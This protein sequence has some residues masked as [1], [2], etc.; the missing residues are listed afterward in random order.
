MKPVEIVIAE[1]QH[2]ALFS[3]LYPGDKDEHGAVLLCGL[4][5]THK[6]RR[7]LVREV[8]LAQDGVGYVS[9]TRGYRQLQPM[10]IAEALD[11][12][13]ENGLYYLAVHNHGAGK[14]VAF[15]KVDTDSHR[16]SYPSLIEI[17]EGR[18]VGALVFA[19]EACAGRIWSREG[20]ED[21]ASYRIIGLHQKLL[22]PKPEPRCD[23]AFDLSLYDRQTRMLGSTGQKTICQLKIGVIGAGG[24]GSIL[25]D[26]L[27]HKGICS[28]VS[29]DPDQLDYTNL[30]R[31][32]GY[33]P[34]DRLRCILS[35]HVPKLAPYKV[36]VVRRAA[37][38]INPKCNVVQIRENVGSNDSIENLVDCNFVFLAADTQIARLIFNLSCQQYMVPGIQLGVKIET[39]NGRL[40]PMTGRCRT[41]LPGAKQGCL[42]CNH[43]LNR[44]KLTEE[45]MDPDSRRQ[46]QYVRDEPAAAIMEFNS[47]VAAQ[48]IA[49]MTGH[50]CGTTNMRAPYLITDFVT[51]ETS[52]MSCSSNPDCPHCGHADSRQVYAK[53]QTAS[54][55][56][57]EFN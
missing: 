56:I 6:K 28:I 29:I 55:P 53:G 52:P 57:L 20:V 33:S 34:L 43:L 24:V 19:T 22:R 16:R 49:A 37:K 45:L 46:M 13:N 4:S 40:G 14:A 51:L 54:L 18:S 31:F 7:L 17:N 9:G 35:K 3:H 23:S 21:V 44:S 15:S 38:R 2:E 26:Q 47:I 5:E 50:F 42:E 1:P 39:S 27:A 41:V 32:A 25:V 12:A 10:F 11:R 48:G 8:L 30:S 36:D